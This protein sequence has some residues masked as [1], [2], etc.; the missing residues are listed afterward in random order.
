VSV[1]V[2]VTLV[3]ER[4]SVGTPAPELADHMI[5]AGAFEAKFIAMRQVQNVIFALRV[6]RERA[7]SL[8][9]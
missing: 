8:Q 3:K 2:Q 9:L 6:Q 7:R 1:A 4:V 5:Q